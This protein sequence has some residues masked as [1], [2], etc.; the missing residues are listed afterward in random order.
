MKTKHWLYLLWLLLM[1]LHPN[2]VTIFAIALIQAIFMFIMELCLYYNHIMST[3]YL[4]CMCTIGCN[5]C[6][7][8]TNR[9]K[10]YDRLIQDY[11]HVHYVII[12]LFPLHY[13][14][15]NLFY[16]ICW[17]CC[18]TIIDINNSFANWHIKY[19]RTSCVHTIK[20]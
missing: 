17:F 6:N 18:F 12:F 13:V 19:S 14:F 20:K 4:F 3:P 10:F 16:L 2:M 1:W 5:I 11:L 15:F 9:Q 8:W 7:I